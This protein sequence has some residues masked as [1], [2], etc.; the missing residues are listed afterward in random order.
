MI[1]HPVPA[2]DIIRY[3]L[4]LFTQLCVE[5]GERPCFISD[6]RKI[7]QFFYERKNQY[8]EMFGR[9]LFARDDGYPNSCGEIADVFVA[10]KMAGKLYSYGH[11]FNPYETSRE[12]LFL[13]ERINPKEK[14]VYQDIAKKFYDDLSCD[15]DVRLG[16]HTD[17]ESL[18][19]LL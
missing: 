14:K 5:K 9:M 17:F 8:P 11:R 10:L 3:T 6:S 18:E 19:E 1:N 13:I 2:L 12:I 4:A 15:K 7:D 16:Q